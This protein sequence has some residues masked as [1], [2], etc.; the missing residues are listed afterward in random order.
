[1]DRSTEITMVTQTRSGDG[2]AEVMQETDTDIFAQVRSAS[3]AEFFEGG[4]SG[5]NPAY[6]FTVFKYEY[7]GQRIVEYGGERYP[8]YRTYETRDD[9]IELYAERKGG[10]NG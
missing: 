6:V 9:N 3:R 8:I 10:V 1:M 2:I 4:R 7:S 5:F